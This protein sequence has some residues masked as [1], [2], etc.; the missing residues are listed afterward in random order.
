MGTGD[1]DTFANRDY[2]RRGGGLDA[3][4]ILW[5]SGYRIS[6]TGLWGR[7]TFTRYQGPFQP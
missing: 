6:V 7:E 1:G 5:A 4:E 2:L 3:R